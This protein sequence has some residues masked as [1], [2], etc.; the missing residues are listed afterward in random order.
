V[1]EIRSLEDL[2]EYA[3]QQVDRIRRMQA[4]LAAQYGSGESPRGLVRART[5]PGGR[6]Q[7]LRIDPAAGGLP[8]DDLAA[9]VMAAIGAAQEE[10]ARRADDIM[11]PVL[12]L[13]PNEQ[14]IQSLEAGLSRLDTL[15]DD[16]NRLARRRD[17]T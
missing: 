1:P 4:D 12:D 10:Y 11:A 13:R 2:A 6:I 7:Q 8:L 5:G 9:E 16:V 15:A 17:P 3:Y 14:A